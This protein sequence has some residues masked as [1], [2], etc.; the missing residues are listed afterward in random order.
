MEITSG[1]P[2]RSALNGL[3]V[4]ELA[5]IAAGPFA[6]GLLADLGATVVHVDEPGA[7]NSIR[8]TSIDRDGGADFTRKVSGRNKRALTLDLRSR[9]DRRL[10]ED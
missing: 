3:K 7:G 2:E 9:R 6:G 8:V 5:Q 10:R 4:L 1:I